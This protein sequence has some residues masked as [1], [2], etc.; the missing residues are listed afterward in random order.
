MPC[1]PG[2]HLRRC[3]VALSL[4]VFLDAPVQG[5]SLDLYVSTDGNDHWSGR[6]PRPA[7]DRRDGPFETLV[8]A[9]DEIRT[10]RLATGYP[11]GGI[12]VWIGS[13]LYPL[14]TGFALDSQ[15]SGEPGSPIE[16]RRA[17]NG[18]VRVIGGIPVGDWHPIT[19]AA[20][21][22]RL[23]ES[24]RR[25]VLEADLHSLGIRDFG[26]IASGA[27]TEPA[28]IELFYRSRPMQLAQWPNEGWAFTGPVP[29]G[30]S[31]AQFTYQGNEP[32]TIGHNRMTS[33]FMDIGSGTGLIRTNR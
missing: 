8:R 5:F 13:G 3:L 29:P 7:A 27:T 33:G 25:G 28:G 31:A 30:D 18:E 14:S 4:A 22:A 19:D 26:K 2:R 17:G 11:I 20:R 10:L 9:R 1:S 16:Y 24:A 23:Q 6:I 12:T 21:A 32:G 15:D